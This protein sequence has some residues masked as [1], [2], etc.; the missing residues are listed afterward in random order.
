MKTL[1]MI[2][3]FSL[4][5]VGLFGQLTPQQKLVYKQ[6]VASYQDSE[7]SGK[8]LAGFGC[9]MGIAG[10]IFIGT[11][12]EIPN[13]TAGIT[14]LSGGAAMAITGFII[15]SASKRKAIEYQERLNLG[16]IYNKECK[17]LSLTYRF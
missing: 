13:R 3:T 12:D 6:K 9:A 11:S 4:L 15:S 2:F 17:G 10:L 8:T 16:M 7:K 14:L 1:L 5:T